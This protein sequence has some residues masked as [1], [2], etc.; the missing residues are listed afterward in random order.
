MNLKSTKSLGLSDDL[1]VKALITGP[2]VPGSAGDVCFL[3]CVLHLSLSSPILC[4]LSNEGIKM[5]K[6]LSKSIH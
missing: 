6:M 3:T 2:S 5:A 1:G 4:H